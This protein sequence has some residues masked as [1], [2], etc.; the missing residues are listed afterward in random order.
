[1]SK[2][3]VWVLTFETNDYDQRGAYFVAVFGKKPTHE[4]LADALKGGSEF[5]T[6]IMG[7]I[8]FLERLL[9]GGGRKGAEHSWYNLEEVDLK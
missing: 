1:M 7:A 6:D 8:A 9:A 3:K 5:P 4:Q 2:P